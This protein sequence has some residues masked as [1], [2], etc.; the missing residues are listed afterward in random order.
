MDW[1]QTLAIM[2]SNIAIMM[3]SIGSTITLFLWARSEANSDRR[4]IQESAAA[5]RREFLSL[6]REIKDEMKEFHGRMERSD[7][8]FKAH[9]MEERRK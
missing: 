1:T 6:I 4:Q 3:V 8:E 2:G 7:T 5:D 9:L